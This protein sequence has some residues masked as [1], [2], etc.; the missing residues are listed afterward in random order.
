MTLTNDNFSDHW[1]ILLIFFGLFAFSGLFEGSKNRRLDSAHL[2]LL[3]MFIVMANVIVLALLQKAA[4]SQ[5]GIIDALILKDLSIESSF[6]VF[7][8]CLICKG[9]GQFIRNQFRPRHKY[10]SNQY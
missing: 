8:Y 7:G 10:Y 1:L 6:I 5:Q 9:I 2:F 4:M 3:G